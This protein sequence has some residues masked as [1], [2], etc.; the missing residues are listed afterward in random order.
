MRLRLSLIIALIAILA[1]PAV[2]LAADPD[3]RLGALDGASE[4]PAVSTTASGTGWAAISSDGTRVTYHV[5]YSGLSGPAT[6]AHIHLGAPGVAGGIML[7]L[8]VGPS[9]MDGILTTAN[10]QATGSVTTFAQALDA[11]RNGQ[12]YFN[13]HTAAHPGGEIRGNLLTTLTAREAVLSGTQE[14]PSVATSG[15]G[16]GLAVLSPGDTSIWYRVDYAGLSG[17]VTA[18]HIHLGAAG[19]A[20]GVMLPLTVGPSP[21]IGFLTA[22]NFQATGGV[23]DFAGAVAAFKSGGT[24][25]N[26]HTAANPPGEIRGQI[27]AAAAAPIPRPLRPTRP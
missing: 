10:F 26:L 13:I 8:T 12:A 17:P 23:T 16:T 24:Y 7:P 19:V 27:G 4:V 1:L 25:F 21:M 22:A 2:A 14:V 11:I 18:A 3:A 15:S 6:A 9:P 20:G 5:E